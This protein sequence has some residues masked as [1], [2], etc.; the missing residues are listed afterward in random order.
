VARKLKHAIEVERLLT[1]AGIDYALET[2]T[3]ATGVVFRTARIGVFFYVAPESVERARGVLQAEGFR[4]H[5]Q[6]DPG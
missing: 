6:T 3:F 5:I 1:D 2:D 4:L